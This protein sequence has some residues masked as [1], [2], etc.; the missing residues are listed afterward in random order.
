MDIKKTSISYDE[1]ISMY[2]IDYWFYT[3]YFDCIILYYIEKW[4]RKVYWEYTPN[5]F[6][7]ENFDLSN[8][9]IWLTKFFDKTIVC[10]IDLDNFSTRYFIVNSCYFID[11]TVHGK[12]CLLFLYIDHNWIE[13]IYHNCDFWDIEVVFDAKKFMDIRTKYEININNKVLWTPIFYKIIYLVQ[14]NSTENIKDNNNLSLSIAD[15]YF[16][17]DDF[18]AFKPD[19]SLFEIM[20]NRIFKVWDHYVKIITKKYD[21][22]FFPKYRI[23]FFIDEKDIDNINLK[24]VLKSILSFYYKQYLSYIIDNNNIKLQFKEYFLNINTIDFEDIDL[25]FEFPNSIFE[26][27]EDFTKFQQN[28]NKLKYA[29][30]NLKSNLKLLNNTVVEWQN[31]SHIESSIIRLSMN[32]NSIEI[33]ISKYE[34]MLKMVLEKIRAIN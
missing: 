2:K 30:Y 29:Y 4:I 32:K 17:E 1:N 20:D 18:Y 24:D 19:L 6:F 33:M 12:H 34:E 27:D 10:L 8:Y 22:F 5:V 16:F 23:S 31:N 7:D 3:K 25:D 9:V 13:K 15:L 21:E 11:F 26:F 28:Y 14:N